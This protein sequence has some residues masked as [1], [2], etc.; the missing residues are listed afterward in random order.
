MVAERALHRIEDRVEDSV[1]DQAADQA[2]IGHDAAINAGT[3]T[4]ATRDSIPAHSAFGITSQ[5]GDDGN[6]KGK[7]RGPNPTIP[8]A[9]GTSNDQGP[10][11]ERQV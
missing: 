11:A 10:T 1:G 3:G 7:G 4:G 6:G 9:A 2:G 5:G 8:M